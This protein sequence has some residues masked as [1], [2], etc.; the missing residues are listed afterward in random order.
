MSY[1][2][3]LAEKRL[4]DIMNDISFLEI[5]EIGSKIFVRITYKEKNY[6]GYLM[7]L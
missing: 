4:N 5:G 7:I 1:M 2:K 3:R 6:D